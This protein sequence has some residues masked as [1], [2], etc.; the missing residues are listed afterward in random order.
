MTDA[1]PV[2][3]RRQLAPPIVDTGVIGWSRK[4][5]FSSWGN[6]YHGGAA[7]RG[8]RFCP[9]PQL[10]VLTA[11]FTARPACLRAWPVG[12]DHENTAISSRSFPYPDHA[13]AARHRHHSSMLIL[14]STCAC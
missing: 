6:A 1:M 13:A 11:V 5:L 3:E 12:A 14:T 10:G 7:R 4:N 2:G 8:A 9:V